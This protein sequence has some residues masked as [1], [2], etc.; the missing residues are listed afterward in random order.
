[1]LRVITFIVCN[2]LG[3]PKKK[4]PKMMKK[5][6]QLT[7]SVKTRQKRKHITTVS[8]LELFG[9]IFLYK[10]KCRRGYQSGNQTLWQEV[11]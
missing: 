4:N 6:K 11:L 2:C 1:M 9:S 10:M 7:F 5:E 3:G 8:G